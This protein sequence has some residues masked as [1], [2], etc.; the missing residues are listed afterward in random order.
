MNVQLRIKWLQLRVKVKP[1]P[2]TEKRF[3]FGEVT[4]T[5]WCRCVPEFLPSVTPPQWR[6][7][8]YKSVRV[9]QI[10]S[11]PLIHA[12]PIMSKNSELN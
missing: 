11:T 7:L 2:G 3:R 5:W 10:Q 12:E 8:F 9:R 4:T 1:S 6:Q